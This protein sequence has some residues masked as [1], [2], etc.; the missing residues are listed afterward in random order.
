MGTAMPLMINIR[1]WSKLYNQMPID[2]LAIQERV[3]WLPVPCAQTTVAHLVNA[4]ANLAGAIIWRNVLRAFNNGGRWLPPV[5][6]LWIA[7]RENVSVGML[8]LVLCQ[9][10]SPN[11]AGRASLSQQEAVPRAL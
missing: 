3:V 2:E 8:P 6:P 1:Q 11:D 5:V 9:L 4:A 10:A 7:I